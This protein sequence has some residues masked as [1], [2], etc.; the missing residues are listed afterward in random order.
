M[1]LFFKL[2]LAALLFFPFFSFAQSNFKPGYVVSLKGDTTHGLIDLKDALYPGEITFKKEQ[3]AGT[4]I[5]TVTEIKAFQINNISSYLRYSG[6]ISTDKI[7]VS[8]ISVGRDTS[9]INKSIFLKLEQAGPHVNLYL[10][11]DNIK[12]RF[13]VKDNH[14]GNISELIFRIYFTEEQGNNTR[15]EDGYKA[16]LMELA[17]K[18]NAS[19]GDFLSM[20]DQ[21]HY[22]A[23]DINAII[24]KINNTNAAKNASG[25]PSVRFYVGL[26]LNSTTFKPRGTDYPFYNATSH[27]SV[28]PKVVA[29]LNFYP[30][31]AVGKLVLKVEISGTK[32]TYTTNVDSYLDSRPLS[33][34]VY[35]FDQ[36]VVALNPQ[37]QY[38]LYNAVNFKF[39][40]DGGVAANFSKYTGNVY[41]NNYSNQTTNDVL[42]VSSAWISF[43]VKIG[44]VLAK[45]FDISAVYIPSAS[46][47]S[48][49]RASSLQAGIAYI[50]H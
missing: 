44:V 12:T 1:K 18:Y 39:Y 7:D 25:E 9:F 4:R 8:K 11:V 22:N 32:N 17:N 34:S 5:L 33:K 40:I 14:T 31:P 10:Y 13:F 3:N 46:M 49:M 35:G 16:Q 27:T 28:F 41:H 6:K 20:I 45:Q 21:A 48:S 2:S 24:H 50:F 23:E 30:N 43:P 38:N 26:L 47:A 19:T 29:G 37:I 36:Y 42:D 15:N